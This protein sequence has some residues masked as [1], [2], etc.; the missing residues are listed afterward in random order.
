MTVNIGRVAI[1]YEKSEIM[2]Y[3][4]CKMISCDSG[5]L[6]WGNNYGSV[7]HVE[8]IKH[9][10]SCFSEVLALILFLS[11]SDVFSFL[12]HPVLE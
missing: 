1:N 12:Y 8:S 6:K 3:K 9:C 10:K 11:N 4:I 5:S 7:L 2:K